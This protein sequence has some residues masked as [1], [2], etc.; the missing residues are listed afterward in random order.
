MSLS[1][2]ARGGYGGGGARELGSVSEGFGRIWILVAGLVGF[3][4]RLL[5][6]VGSRTL[7]NANRQLEGGS[8]SME[9]EGC[10]LKL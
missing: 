7:K 4:G 6:G 5:V 9:S 2:P 3:V 8:R 1:S 10:N